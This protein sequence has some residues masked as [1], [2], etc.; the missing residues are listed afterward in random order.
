MGRNRYNH[1]RNS[2]VMLDAGYVSIQAID[3]YGSTQIFG[4]HGGKLFCVIVMVFLLFI[5]SFIN[6]A[7]G[8]FDHHVYKLGVSFV[9]LG[10]Y[11]VQTRL[12]AAT[13][14]WLESLSIR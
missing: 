10:I 3:F 9:V 12:D 8:L 1:R 5:I 2:S 14:K 7:V 4:L 13:Q 11:H 6:L